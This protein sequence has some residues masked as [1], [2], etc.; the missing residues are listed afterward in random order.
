[1]LVYRENTTLGII[2]SK[3]HI[4]IHGGGCEAFAPAMLVSVIA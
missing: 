4:F 2:K 1:M 3:T